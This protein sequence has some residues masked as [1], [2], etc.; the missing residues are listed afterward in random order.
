MSDG[1]DGIRV[2]VQAPDWIENGSITLRFTEMRPSAVEEII[3]SLA[4]ID[5]DDPR[6]RILKRLW[7]SLLGD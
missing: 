1:N 6:L 3:E 2:T 5:A 4:S 7:D